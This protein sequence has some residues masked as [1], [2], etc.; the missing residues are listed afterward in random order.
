MAREGAMTTHADLA[1][2]VILLTAGIA[3]GFIIVGGVLWLGA[4]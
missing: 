4:S 2:I 3:I 1:R